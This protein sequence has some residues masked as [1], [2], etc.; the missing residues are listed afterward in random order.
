M[1]KLKRPRYISLTK[2]TRRSTREHKEHLI[3]QIRNAIDDYDHLYVFDLTGCRTAL[4][5]RARDQLKP[6]RMFM[7]K[8]TVMARALGRQPSEEAADNIHLVSK[9]L[10]GV[11]GLLFSN[12]SL[13]DVQD[14]FRR[15]THDEYATEGNIAPRTVVIPEGPTELPSSM[16]EV[17]VRLNLPLKVTDAVIHVLHDFTLVKEGAVITPE[18]AKLLKHF[19]IP[20][21]QFQMVLKCQWTKENGEFEEFVDVDDDSE[22]DE[23][24]DEDMKN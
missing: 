4:V 14:F 15:F 20:L 13:D 11:S 18:Q 23:D 12:R 8:T 1:T 7:A 3:E 9:H 17:L 21:S 22:E 24:E 19:K 2:T 5:K 10:R 6:D 16:E